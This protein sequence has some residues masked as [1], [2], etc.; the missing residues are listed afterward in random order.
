[1]TEHWE[2]VREWINNSEAIANTIGISPLAF[3][4]AG[5]LSDADMLLAVKEAAD[6]I[7]QVSYK[8]SVRSLSIECPHGNFPSYPSHA[9]WCDRCFHNLE[10]A[11]AALPNHLK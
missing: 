4:I 8:A 5:L 3:D 9:W 1:M 10:D 7:F 2:S 11:L 6:I